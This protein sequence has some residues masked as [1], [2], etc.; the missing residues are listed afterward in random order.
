MDKMLIIRVMV[1]DDGKLTTVGDT[2][3][4]SMAD[5]MQRDPE[6]RTKTNS[7]LLPNG[8]NI[9]SIGRLMFFYRMDGNRELIEEAINETNKAK[10]RLKDLVWGRKKWRF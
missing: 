1:G 7:L 9:A 8:T 10:P 6:W 2:T 5:S 4:E 3:P